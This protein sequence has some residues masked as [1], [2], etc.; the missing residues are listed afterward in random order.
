MNLEQIREET[1]SKKRLYL[2]WLKDIKTEQATLLLAFVQDAFREDSRRGEH[3]D[4]KGN[5]ILAACFTA[6]G[7]MAILSKSAVE[8]I[9]GR[10]IAFTVAMILAILASRDDPCDP[11]QLDRIYLLRFVGNPS[12]S[13]MV[14][15]KS[16]YSLSKRDF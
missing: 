7:V 4:Q 16:R 12:Y 6:I 9:N 2:E 3:L 10:E 15:A 5:W 13:I 1:E 14:P 11:C 8:A